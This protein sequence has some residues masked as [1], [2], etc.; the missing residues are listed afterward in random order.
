MAN[1]LSG[2]LYQ[3][4]SGV[5]NYLDLRNVNNELMAENA[6]LRARLSES[7]FDNRIDTGRVS[8][9]SGRY[10]QHYSY[11]SAQ[12]IRNSVSQSSNFIYLNKGSKHGI[13]KQMGVINANGIVGQVISVSDNFSVAMSVL[14]KD[15]KVSAKFKKNEYFGNL[16][17]TGIQSNTAML[18]EIPKHVPVAVGDTIVTSGFSELFPR[19]IL[20]GTVKKFK[21][22][23]DKNFLDITIHL[24]TNFGSLN[25]VYI[26]NNMKRQEIIKLDS[27]IVKND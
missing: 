16:R 9:S 25:Y 19:N 18:E 2:W 21:M 24:S 8:D 22:E 10:V 3:S 23:P 27:T 12:V 20:V 14:S 1:N 6:A 26:V 15:F 11:I 5:T 17:W 13:S 4:Y 7:L